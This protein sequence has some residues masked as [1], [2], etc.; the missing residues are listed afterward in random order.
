MPESEARKTL[1]RLSP[2]NRMIDPEEVAAMVVTL[3]G[4]L[5]QGINGQAINIDGGTVMF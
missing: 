5:A 4:D 1:E 2:Q 3:A